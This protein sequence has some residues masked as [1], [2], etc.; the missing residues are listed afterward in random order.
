MATT[1]SETPTEVWSAWSDA[2]AVPTLP[3]PGVVLAEGLAAAREAVSRAAGVRGTALSNDD[4][5]A[6][7]HELAA[8]RS[9]VEALTLAVVA[10]AKDRGRQGPTGDAADPDPAAWLGR[11]TGDPG[12]VLRGGLWIAQLLQ[13]TYHHVRGALEDGRLRLSQAKILVR[14]AERAPRTLTREQVAEAEA[15]LVLAATGEGT[16][17]G[18][19]M[20]AAQLRREA[21]RTFAGMLPT[22]PEAD[23][24][25]GDD[26]AADEDRA[27]HETYLTLGDRGDGTWG[28][29][30]VLPDLHARLLLSA[31][32]HLGS[33]RRLGRDATGRAVQDESVATTG[34]SWSQR[35]GAALCELLEHLPA[36]GF[37]RGSAVTLL[38]KVPL[39][40]LRAG[41]GA[42]ALDDGAPVS[43]RTARRLACNAGHLPVVLGGRGVPLDLGHGRRLFGVQHERAVA[44]IHD[45]CGIAGCT[46][47]LAWCELHHLVPWS[48]GG[49]T[50][51]GNAL[52]LCGFHH[53][54]AHDPEYELTPHHDHEHVLRR[55]RRP[56]R[57]PTAPRPGE[58][59]TP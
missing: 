30:L 19:P 14:A 33:P 58:D 51:L 41:L 3:K 17:S 21:R 28:G 6:A 15:S 20:P 53:R 48:R 59:P 45:T 5:T 27:E 31:L 4:L 8:L 42:G 25:E 29:R 1:T 16:R 39:E 38:V 40:T 54:R 36:D 24:A 47:P 49:R 18:R 37:R 32:E 13:S 23:A 9:Q 11:L 44:A 50:D 35:M 2:Y 34:M 43:A 46:R 10:E 26:V 57:R 56:R 7:A 55:R 22:R 52:P 12:E